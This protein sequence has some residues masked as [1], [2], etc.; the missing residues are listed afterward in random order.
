MIVVN[1][2]EQTILDWALRSAGG[3]LTLRLFKNNVTPTPT[4]VAGDFTEADFTGYTAKTLARASYGAPATNG[5]GE[6]EISYADQTFSFGSAQTIYGYYLTDPSNALVAAHDFANPRNQ[7]ANSSFIL[8]PKFRLRQL[9]SG[10]VVVTNVGELELLDWILK[11]AGENTVL[12]LYTNNYTPDATSVVGDFTEASFGGYA[13]Q[14][15]T[16]ASWNAPY[17]DGGIGTMQYGSVTSW[18]PTTTQTI[19]GF[20]VTNTANTKVLWAQKYAL[21]EQATSGEDY[22]LQAIFTARSLGS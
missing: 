20:Y 5:S 15:L 12:R 9:S 7:N 6:A 11:S 8:Q 13:A 22:E 21:D 3:A 19:R 4:S 2:G 17:D 18:T 10:S 14:T 1:A 16:R